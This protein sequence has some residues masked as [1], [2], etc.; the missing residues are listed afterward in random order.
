MTMPQKM[1]SKKGRSIQRKASETPASSRRKARSSKRLLHSS[2]GTPCRVCARLRFGTLSDTAKGG[3]RQIGSRSV[4]VPRRC[5]YAYRGVRLRR[6]TIRARCRGRRQ[7]HVRRRGGKRRGVFF[8]M[9][10]RPGKG[11]GRPGGAGKEA[12]GGSAC[13]PGHTASLARTAC[14]PRVVKAALQ[15]AVP[16]RPAGAAWEKCFEIATFFAMM[17][18]ARPNACCSVPDDP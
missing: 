13:R 1:T 7:R 10:S 5:P 6:L 2:M 15:R 14:P 12:A 18:R 16:C 9:S 8:R 11:Q 17:K 3:G 4:C